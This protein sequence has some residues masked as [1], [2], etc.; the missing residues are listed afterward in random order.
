MSTP[1]SSPSLS[2]HLTCELCTYSGSKHPVMD[3]IAS[4][5]SESVE[6]MPLAEICSQVRA[7]ASKLSIHMSVK[8]IHEHFYLH[9]CEQAVVLNH[10]LRDLVDIVRLLKATA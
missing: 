9:R 3:E 6:H 4:F 1:L 10:V 7:L 5:S 2:H 8:Q